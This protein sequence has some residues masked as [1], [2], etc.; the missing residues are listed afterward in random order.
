[1]KIYCINLNRSVERRK[2]QLSQAKRLNIDLIFVDA[3]DYRNI[4]EKELLQAA[5][6]W[7][8]PINGKDIG[9][10][11]SHKNCWKIIAQNNEPA[12]IIEDDI[13]FSIELKKILHAIANTPFPKNRVYDLE[14]VPHR[15]TLAVD[16]CWQVQDITAT[17]IYVN[18]SGAGCYV[19]TPYVAEQLLNLAGSYVMVD[20]WLW[21]RPWLEQIQIEPCPAIQ[22]IYIRKSDDV[23]INKS[24]DS[25]KNYKQASYLKKKYIRLKIIIDQ[26]NGG[27]LKSLIWGNKRHLRVSLDSFNW[28]NE[29]NV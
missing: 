7:T 19:L 4:D 26:I 2:F 27:V 22:S 29:I 20:S 15:H 1:M 24:G 9:C 28:R 3:T 8:R 13:I 6:H 10:F 5:N 16:P 21:T 12:M 25:L 18:K 23:S 17:R 14:Y 11:Q